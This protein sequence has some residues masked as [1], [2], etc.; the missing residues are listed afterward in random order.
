VRH[1][2]LALLLAASLAVPASLLLSGAGSARAE[3]SPP[4][5]ADVAAPVTRPSGL[6]YSVLQDGR[7]GAAP[8]HGDSVTVHYTGWL[9]NGK[10]FDSSRQRGQPATFPVGGLIAAWN[11]ALT[12]MTPGS[13][14]KLTVPPALGYGAGGSP[15]AIPGNATLIFDVELISFRSTPVFRAGNP[16]AQ[17]KTA[18]GLIL[19]TLTEGGGSAATLADVVELDYA[20]WTT[21]GKL[22]DHSGRPGGQTLKQPAADLPLA[23]L[24]EAVPLMKVGGRLW[25]KVPPELAFGAQAQGRDLPPN[26]TTIWEVGLVAIK[27]PLPC[28][29]FAPSAAGAARKLPSG[30]EIEVLAEGTGATPRLHQPVTV[31]YAGWLTDGTLFDSSY[32]RGEPATFVLGQVI[33]GWNEGLQLMKEGGKARFTIPGRLAY[34]PAGR[35]PKIGPDATLVFV[36]ELIKAGG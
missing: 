6:V 20:L 28:P 5:P 21:A 10:V 12:L 29:P 23:F 25:L 9:T 30:L 24:K 15:P 2:S 11:E 32:G 36:V 27:Q 17:V 1:A 22:L 35:P 7:G 8:K 4:I 18:S 34:G 14:W 19:E 13:R 3:D 33:A 16:A 31:H 26:S